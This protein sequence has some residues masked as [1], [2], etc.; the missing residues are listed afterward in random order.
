MKTDDIQAE[1]NKIQKENENRK[2]QLTNLG[3]NIANNEKAMKLINEQID[4]VNEE[5]LKFGQLIIAKQEVIEAKKAEIELAEQKISEKDLEIEGRKSEIE[6]LK[7]KNK[8]NL[9]KQKTE[10][11]SEMAALEQEENELEIYAAEQKLYLYSLAAENKALK[12]KIDSLEY[13]IKASNKK[14]DELDKELQELIRK[15]QEAALGSNGDYSS[16]F[17]WPLD[18]KFRRITTPFG[19]DNSFG[20]RNHGGIDVAGGPYPI[21]STNIYAVQ[22][23]KVIAVYNFCPHDSIKHYSC[24]C[25]GG[26]GNYIIID[27]G[28][29]VSTLYAHCRKIFVSKG[30]QVSKG[31][32]IALVGC[33]GWSTGDHLHF[34]VRENGYRVN[35]FKYKYQYY[36]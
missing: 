15:E 30:Q 28:G 12:D 23:G 17:R 21:G 19:W 31:D 35:P 18:P 6:A 8:S 3:A 32:V 14:L 27:H 13:D 4:G 29:G 24:G 2:N 26:F 11:E 10:L 16:G 5:I 22:S 25:G 7:A 20:G 1:I 36:N 33:T 9:Q 34:E